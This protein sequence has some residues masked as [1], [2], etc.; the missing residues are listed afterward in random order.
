[1][2]DGSTFSLDAVIQRVAAATVNSPAQSPS[3][4]DQD[5]D[6][7]SMTASVTSSSPSSAVEEMLLATPSPSSPGYVS[8]VLTDD[9][10]EQ[11]LAN[12]I[13]ASD[14][15]AASHGHLTLPPPTSLPSAVGREWSV[16]PS[17][18]TFHPFA[19]IAVVSHSS[20][21]PSAAAP[22]MSPP[23]SSPSSPLSDIV[24][25][26]IYAPSFDDED[27]FIVP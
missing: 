9:E 23:P 15:A 22:T 5:C 21:S 14:T 17:D 11:L 20:V 24:D 6:D 26:T 16:S 2:I 7:E 10:I 27:C 13:A 18:S 3:S 25:L 8:S 4:D 19:P 1:M 12:V